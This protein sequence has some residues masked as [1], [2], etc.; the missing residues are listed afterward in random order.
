MEDT[1]KFGLERVTN[2]YC[3]I[4]NG[5]EYALLTDGISEGFSVIGDNEIP[6]VEEHFV[7]KKLILMGAGASG[8]D[9]YRDRIVKA[10]LKKEISYTTREPREGE[11]D[12]ESYHFVSQKEFNRL[13][14]KEKFLQWNKFGNEKCYGTLIEDFEKF[15]VFIMT[16]SA[17]KMMTSEQREKSYVIYFKI[18]EEIRRKRLEER[19]DDNDDLE[20]RLGTDRVDFDGFDDYDKVVIDENFEV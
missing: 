7:P 16:P 8:K 15:D 18:P 1:L 4:K 13:I 3:S 11:V 2:S 6:I 14:I 12:G 9:Y 5:C 19:S 20:R 17:L 10:G